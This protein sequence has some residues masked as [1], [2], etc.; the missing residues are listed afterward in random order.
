[1][2]LRHNLAGNYE[3]KFPCQDMVQKGKEKLY[4]YVNLSICT[5]KPITTWHLQFTCRIYC[6]QLAHLL[7]CAYR[8][9]QHY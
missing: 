7:Y 1:M 5:L 6:L 2:N 9:A 3:Y 4:L 8:R